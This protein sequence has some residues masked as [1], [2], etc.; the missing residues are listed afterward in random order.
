MRNLP[1]IVKYF[2]DHYQVKFFLTGSASFYLKNLFSES[3][4]GRK[5]LFELFP[6]SFSEFLQFKRAE[7]V[8][9]K[10]N[11]KM[12]ETEFKII[13]PFWQEYLEFGGFPEVVN[14]NEKEK[15]LKEYLDLAFYK[16][17]VERHRIEKIKAL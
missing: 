15:T 12:S 11:L 17:F 7:I 2:Y 9:P 3:L 14:Y 10:K 8:L 16:D 5:Y 1:S 13:E 6:L 4:S